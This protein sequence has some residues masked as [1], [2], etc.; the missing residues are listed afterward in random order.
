MQRAPPVTPPD[1]NDEV[2]A[3]VQPNA[4]AS[5]PGVSALSLREG[6]RRGRAASRD[7]EALPPRVDDARAIRRELRRVRREYREALRTIGELKEAVAARDEM[8]AV[9]GHELRNPMGAVVV[10]VTH[11]VFRG[12]REGDLP[13]W[14]GL[15]LDALEKQARNFVRRATT[16]LDVSRL[17]TG[18]PQLNHEPLD[19]AEVVKDTAREM[20][21]EAEASGC[22]LRLALDAEVIGSWDR[23]A[24]EQIVMNLLSNAIKYGAGRPVDVSVASDGTRA[25]LSVRD[26]GIGIE[27][28]DRKRIFERFERAVTRRDRPGF[29]LGLWITRQL[30][31]AHGGEIAVESQAGVGSVFTAAL[32]RGISAPQR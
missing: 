1:P 14:V 26:Q 24:V 18:R 29:G 16:L 28:S 17:T 7:P 8:I 6:T 23:A 21:G 4:V 31:V 13:E 12:R 25:T 19:L 32:P 11:M 10:N 2:F 20:A 5:R 30:V 15:R 3:V 22:E 9:A 27:E